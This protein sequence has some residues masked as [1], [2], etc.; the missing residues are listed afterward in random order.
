MKLTGTAFYGVCRDKGIGQ[1][2]IIWFTSPFRSS[3]GQKGR[4]H[5]TVNNTGSEKFYICFNF[6]TNNFNLQKEQFYLLSLEMN[7]HRLLSYPL[8]SLLLGQILYNFVS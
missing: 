7:I 2:K 3:I 4:G 6:L 8:R 5:W 1:L